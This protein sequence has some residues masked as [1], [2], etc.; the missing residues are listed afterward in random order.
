MQRMNRTVSSLFASLLVAGAALAQQTSPVSTP[1]IPTKQEVTKQV[2]KQVQKPSKEQ[3]E[4]ITK[5]KQQEIDKAKKY[6]EKKMDEAKKAATTTGIQIGDVAPA[7]SLTDTDGKTVDLATI[8]KDGDKIV[9]LEWYNPDCPFVKKHHE[10]NTTFKDLYTK[11]QDKK[12]V[13]LAINSGA[14][15]EQG[16]GK[17]R[18]AKA[19]KDDSIAYPILLDENGEVGRTYGAQRTP[20]MFV[21]GKTGKIEY[22]GAIDDDSSVDSAGKTN[23]V[24]KA[25]GELLAGTS[26]TTT[27]TKPYGCSVKY[28]KKQGN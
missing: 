25:L 19:K 17:E 10:N 22:Q 2:E 14:K 13:F 1:A 15:G 9:V 27:E 23:Y 11:Y 16:F 21:I 20:H 7:F 5:D 26:V 4:K 8:L 18:N 12:V 3:L 28:A 24:D 6:G